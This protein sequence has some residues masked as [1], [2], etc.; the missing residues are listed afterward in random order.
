MVCH[1]YVWSVDG[2]RIIYATDTVDLRNAPE[3][4]YDYFFIESNYDTTKL[5]NMTA[6]GKFGYNVVAGAKRHMST[7]TC[8]AFYYMNRRD[9]ESKL[10]ELH[11]SGRFY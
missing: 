2:E 8:K 3:G 1:G 10:I 9:Q 11:M 4:Q 6:R 5:L 7:Q